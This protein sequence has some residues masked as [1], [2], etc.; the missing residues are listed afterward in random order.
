MR[1]VVEY[2]TIFSFIFMLIFGLTFF[3]LNES[4]TE[5]ISNTIL[6][7]SNDTK[8]SSLTIYGY[9]SSLTFDS[10]TLDYSIQMIV[11][12]KLLSLEMNI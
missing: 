11:V 6:F 2:I 12:L 10:D 7:D 1:K 9:E 4:H 3:N 8:L 5:E